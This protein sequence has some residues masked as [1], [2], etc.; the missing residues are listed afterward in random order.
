MEP[1]SFCG[2]EVP[3]PDPVEEEGEAWK[4]II[5]GDTR[6]N[7]RAHRNVLRSIT[8][9]TPD[10]RFL[11]NVGDVVEDG[12]SE[13]QWETWQDACNDILGGTGQN[14]VPPK[15]MAV[16]GNHDNLEDSDGRRNWLQFLPGQN[17]QFGN[18]GAFSYSTMKMPG[19]LF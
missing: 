13:S 14:N 10:Y 3:P 18:N 6:T 19:L 16:P 9:N 17:E 12:N 4:F 1:Q 2:D 8:N 15:Y 5:Y 11:I 7:D